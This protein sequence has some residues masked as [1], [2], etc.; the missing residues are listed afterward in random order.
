M[1]IDTNNHKNPNM[2]DPN[3]NNPS[4]IQRRVWMIFLVQGLVAGF[5]FV[6]FLGLTLV[7]GIPAN[8]RLPPMLV[9][10]FFVGAAIW[11]WEIRA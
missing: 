9:I 6:S 2:S 8:R 5:I 10:T 3:A 4:V 11:I 1:T 7:L